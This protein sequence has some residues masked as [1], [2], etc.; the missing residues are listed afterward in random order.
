MTWPGSF[1]AFLVSCYPIV[2][3]EGSVPSHVLFISLVITALL[4]SH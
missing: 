1:Q 3:A 4:L 2:I